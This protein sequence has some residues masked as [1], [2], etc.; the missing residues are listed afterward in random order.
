MYSIL[1]SKMKQRTRRKWRWYSLSIKETAQA[2]RRAGRTHRE[3][4]QE[5]AVGVGSAHLWTKGILLSPQQRKEI[6][7]RKAKKVFTPQLRKKLGDMARVRLAPYRERYTKEDLLKKIR[8]FYIQH[9]RIP[10]KREFNMPDAYRRWFGGW[11]NAIRQAG[12]D[13]NSVLFAKK[14]V[15][16]D[17]HMCDS[18][19]EKV[20][21]DLLFTH[22]IPH[23][24]NWRYGDT[25]MT[26]DFF[27]LPNI[28]IEFFG[29]VGAQRSYDRIIEQKREF[30]EEHELQLIE[31]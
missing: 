18:F 31:L 9:G 24:R 1:S 21:D 26:A 5:L 25:K 29:L 17:G 30:C 15:S 28:I 2:L 12:F 10:L 14:F 19:S 7:K 4:A 27:I 11:N 23:E 13:P 22:R 6:Q 20:I 8:D 3:I 16:T